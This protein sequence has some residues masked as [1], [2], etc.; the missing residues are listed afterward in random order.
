MTERQMPELNKVM[1]LYVWYSDLL[2]M[3]KGRDFSDIVKQKLVDSVADERRIVEHILS[4]ELKRTGRYDE[5][6]DVLERQI[7]QDPNDVLPASWL[8]ELFLG[9]QDRP[10]EA[11]T[12]IDC[13]IESTKRLRAFRRLALGVKGR[14]A[15]RLGRYDLLEQVLLS[16]LNLRVKKDEL[17]IGLERD[18]FDRADRDKLSEEVAVRYAAMFKKGD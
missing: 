7:R 8:A 4:M 14:V 2:K 9:F 1:S 3:D 18:F 12:A 15:I 17:D 11:L 10:E 13:A 6:R 16:I 5:A